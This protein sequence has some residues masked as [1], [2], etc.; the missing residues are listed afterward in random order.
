MRKFGFAA[1]AAG[2]VAAALCFAA[3]P[4][5]R[6]EMQVLESNVNAYPVGKRLPDGTTFNLKPGERIQV[7]L[8]PSNVTKV[9]Q[10]APIKDTTPG[11]TRG[12]RKKTE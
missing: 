6:A 3:V 10:G 2:A 8:L 7:L 12:V 4:S 11:G 1:W 5:A 9:F